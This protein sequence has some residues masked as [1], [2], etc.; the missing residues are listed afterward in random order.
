MGFNFHKVDYHTESFIRLTLAWVIIR[1]LQLI[2]M[3]DLQILI[4]QIR[5]VVPKGYTKKNGY[6]GWQRICLWNQFYA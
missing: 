6:Y 4:Q 5:Q 1:F 2:W 3:G